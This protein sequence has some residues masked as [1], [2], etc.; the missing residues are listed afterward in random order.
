MCDK[1]SKAIIKSI[2]RDVAKAKARLIEQYRIK[3]LC[4]NFGENEFH[5]LRDKYGM[6]YTYQ[7]KTRGITDFFN[8]CINFTGE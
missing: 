2:A 5:K 4:E 8:W 6:D 7:R 3:G 1:E